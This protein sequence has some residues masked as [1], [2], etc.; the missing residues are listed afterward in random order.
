MLRGDL[1]FEFLIEKLEEC[2]KLALSSNSEI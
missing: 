1:V 2:E